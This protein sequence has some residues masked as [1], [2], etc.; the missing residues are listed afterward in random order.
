MKE[1]KELD[2]ILPSTLNECL[3]IIDDTKKVWENHIENLIEI[4]PFFGFKDENYNRT[5]KFKKND[6][7]DILS[8][9]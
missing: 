3:L 8:L 1:T 6:D 9:N 2:K 5:F 4:I 7:K